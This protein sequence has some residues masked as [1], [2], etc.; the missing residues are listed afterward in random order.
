MRI[1]LANESRAG[2]GGVETYLSATAEALRRRGHEVALLY[3]NR[4]AEPGATLIATTESWS[5]A[6]A[7][8]P[9]VLEQVRKWR[10]DV[11]FAHNMRELD[12]DAAL[13]R[14]GPVVKMMHGYFGTCVSG[15]KA[16][17]A[18]AAA[19]CTRI[20]GP[21]CLVYFAPRRCGRRRPLEVV[22]HYRWA[23][24]QRALFPKYRSFVVASEHM[25]GEYV[26]HGVA[27]DR[28]QA[29]PLFAA[30]PSRPAPG[31]PTLDVLFLG[32]MTELK[33]PALLLD[34]LTRASRALGRRLSV[35]MAG[36]GPL[37]ERLR[38]AAAEIAGLDAT[39][40]GWVGSRARAELLGRAALLAVPSV[41]PE[42]FGLV[43]LEAA[44]FGI[45]AVAFDV[46]GI[47]EWLTDGVNG[48]LIPAG[49]TAA[50]GNAIT[51]LLK[52][53]QERGRLGA[54]AH[55]V[56]GRFSPDAHLS[57]LEAVLERARQ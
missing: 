9:A 55:A 31:G 40:P 48:R 41:W 34:A 43:G 56:F 52:D 42:P 26:A 27:P 35:V 33:G 28:I 49:D 17:L 25:R 5:V 1:L 39:F 44:A 13:L 19:A 29:I 51:A 38:D 6:D 2:A 3:A 8:L 21:A 53:P 22:R 46:G 15:Q 14:E 24:R 10:P 36:E 18:P 16:F 4:A 32:R 30:E 12:I 7:G 45:P 57:R 20:C 54:G 11:C 37:R 47:R 50:M 23:T